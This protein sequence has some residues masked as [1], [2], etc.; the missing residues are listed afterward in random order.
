VRSTR[1]TDHR[2]GPL[3][4][5]PQDAGSRGVAGRDRDP[6]VASFPAERFDKVVLEVE[7]EPDD[8]YEIGRVRVLDGIGDTIE[9]V[10]AKTGG[11]PVRFELDPKTYA[12]RAVAEGYEEGRTEQPV[13]LYASGKWK[14][15]LRTH[16][17]S[18]P[19]KRG[20]PKKADADAQ[21]PAEQESFGAVP[22]P[23][24]GEKPQPGHVVAEAPDRLAFR[25]GTR[26]HGSSRRGGPPSPRPGP[27]PRL[28]PASHR[29]AGRDRGTAADRACAGRTRGADVARVAPGSEGCSAAG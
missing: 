2:G 24:P 5:V 16:N 15:S 27:R 22:L 12:L 29:D 7:L 28:L 25:R 26:Q 8:V 18:A 11:R 9:D 3:I 20:A 10:E 4:Q 19:A 23:P 21:T 17:G 13:E 1:R 6:V 14:I